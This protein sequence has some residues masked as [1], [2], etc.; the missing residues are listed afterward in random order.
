MTIH[1]KLFDYYLFLRG[2]T[3]DDEEV[4]H[5]L[6]VVCSDF[7]VTSILFILDEL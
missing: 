7:I 2:L 6:G 3:S 1:A 4:M 5:K